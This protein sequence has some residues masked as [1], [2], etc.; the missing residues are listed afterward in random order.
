MTPWGLVGIGILLQRNFNAFN[1]YYL[2]TTHIFLK[3]ELFCAL[4]SNLWNSMPPT[5]S[6]CPYSLLADSHKSCFAPWQGCQ[7]VYV[8][9]GQLDQMLLQSNTGIHASMNF[10]VLVN[11][12]SSYNNW[13]FGEI[14]FGS[15]HSLR[16]R[17]SFWRTAGKIGGTFFASRRITRMWTPRIEASTQGRA[18]G[19]RTGINLKSKWRNIITKNADLFVWLLG[20]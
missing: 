14:L 11:S 3:S 12:C 5:M 15:L 7:C 9:W 8:Y 20:D 2:A 6:F 17:L 10:S 1:L 4:A 13:S 19:P 16:T 18:V